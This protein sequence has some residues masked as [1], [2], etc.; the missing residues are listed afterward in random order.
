M[1]TSGVHS[2]R[3]FIN[4]RIKYRL[5]YDPRNEIRLLI[6]AGAKA[7]PVI[8]RPFVHAHKGDK[9]YMCKLRLIRAT[10]GPHP[11]TLEAIYRRIE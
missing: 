1:T 3:S 10:L 7:K 11:G 6:G 8:E 4:P 5:T 2:R 9:N